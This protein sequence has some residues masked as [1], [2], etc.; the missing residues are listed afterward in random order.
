VRHAEVR[1]EDLFVR[2]WIRLLGIPLL[3]AG[4]EKARQK[5]IIPGVLHSARKAVYKKLRRAPNHAA[6]PGLLPM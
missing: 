4:L 5:I 3:C 6:G 2:K 1:V